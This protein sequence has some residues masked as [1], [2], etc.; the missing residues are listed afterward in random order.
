MRIPLITFFLIVG[1]CPMLA[2]SQTKPSQEKQLAKFDGAMSPSWKTP[3]GMVAPLFIDITVSQFQPIE[4]QKAAEILKSVS[5]EGSELGD[6]ITVLANIYEVE[7]PVIKDVHISQ[8]YTLVLV[9]PVK[10]TIGAGELKNPVT[11]TP[12][13]VT[14]LKQVINKFGEPTSKQIWSEVVTRQIGLDGI[15][16]WWGEIGIA[17]ND[18]GKITH[19]LRRRAIKKV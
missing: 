17:A 10:G 11:F 3:E 9:Y 1:L 4:P 2:F 16:C 14:D 15:L 7:A 18:A 12:G 8:G 19:V 5:A 13:P 6:M